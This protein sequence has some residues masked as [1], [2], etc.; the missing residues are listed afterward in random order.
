MKIWTI[1]HDAR[2]DDGTGDLD[3]DSFSS[4]KAAMEAAESYLDSKHG[5]PFVEAGDI[6][7]T[8][9]G[10]FYNQDNLIEIYSQTIK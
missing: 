6:G 8:E 10:N 9:N 4:K 2:C 5:P 7:W 1:S 3:G